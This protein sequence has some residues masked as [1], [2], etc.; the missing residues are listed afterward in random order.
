MGMDIKSIWMSVGVC[1]P[2][3]FFVCIWP[4]HEGA[5]RFGQWG[6]SWCQLASG[7]MVQSHQIAI[8]GQFWLYTD[9][10]TLSL[11]SPSI[12]LFSII[13][14]ASLSA[15]LCLDVDF[16]SGNTLELIHHSFLNYLTNYC[17]CNTQLIP[18]SYT[19]SLGLR[20]SVCT[21]CRW[22][23]VLISHK[24]KSIYFQMSMFF[25]AWT[26]LI[27]I[28]LQLAT[29]ASLQ[30]ANPN[31]TWWAMHIAL[32]LHD[33]PSAVMGN[34]SQSPFLTPSKRTHIHPVLPDIR[35]KGVAGGTANG[36]SFVTAN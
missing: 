33:P 16:C 21:I 1:M 30:S 29:D 34:F 27:S 26:S 23:T 24:P 19:Q 9:V 10:L 31:R 4:W 17:Q 14:P 8:T 28:L 11:L 36:A 12:P 2:W 6:A 3:F 20:G 35:N 13:N 18:N 5:G 22:F 32:V 25:S 7:H 15:S